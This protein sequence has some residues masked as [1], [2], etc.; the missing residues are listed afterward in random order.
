MSAKQATEA[1]RTTRADED[2]VDRAVRRWAVEITELDPA[3]EALVER[4]SKI[5]KLLRRSMAETAEGF[6][7]TIEDWELLAKL[8]WLGPPYR[9]T[10]GHLADQLSLSPAAMTGRLDR[11]EKRGLVRRLPDSEDRRS[12]QVELTEEGVE[13]WNRTVGVQ[14]MKE[15]LFAGVLTAAEKDALN[16]MLRRLMKSLDPGMAPGC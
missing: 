7:L 4:V 5:N 16:D 12:V 13:A 14:A 8:R 10:P 9:L 2:W 11:L 15:R 1:G 3:T 6:G